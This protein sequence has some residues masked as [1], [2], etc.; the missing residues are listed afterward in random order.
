MHILGFPAI[1][2]GK[3][4]HHSEISEDIYSDTNAKIYVDTIAGARVEFKTL[5]ASIAGE[6]GDI[7]NGYSNTPFGGITIFHSMGKNQLS[8]TS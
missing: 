3:N 7:I 2:A 6:I 4:G 5:K 8:N 1:G